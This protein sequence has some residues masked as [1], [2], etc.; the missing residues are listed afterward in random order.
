MEGKFIKIIS[1][2]YKL[3]ELFPEGDPLKNKAKEL[4]LLIMEKLSAQETNVTLAD[5]VTVLENYLELAKG[6]GW[7][8]GINFLI[9][10]K[11]WER[12]KNEIFSE[13]LRPKEI[14]IE[15]NGAEKEQHYSDRQSKILKILAQKEKLQVQ[16]IIKEMPDVTKRTIRRD[17]DDLLKKGKVARLGEFNQIFYTK[18]GGRLIGDQPERLGHEGMHLL[19]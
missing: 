14:G 11:E 17:L 16:D 7:I 13:P 8:H 1:A 3:L 5:D 18:A 10:K 2:T 19:S 12:V 4:V 15:T 6:Q 9:I